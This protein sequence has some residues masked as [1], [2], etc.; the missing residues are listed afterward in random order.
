MKNYRLKSGEAKERVYLQHKVQTGKTGSGQP[1]EDWQNFFAFK[2]RAKI[3][4][5][6]SAEEFAG[7]QLEATATHDIRIDYRAGV[8]HKMRVADAKSSRIFEI[9]QI[10]DLGEM[11]QTLLLECTEATD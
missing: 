10:K 8:T 2:L 9:V 4:P 5:R 7:D 3:T 1:Q 11:K 6:R